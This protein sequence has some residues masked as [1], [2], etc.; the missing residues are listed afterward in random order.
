MLRSIRVP[1]F[2]GFVAL[3]FA[4][5]GG[6][7]G[8]GHQTDG[9][10][11]GDGPHIQFDGSHD[12]TTPQQDGGGGGDGG[13]GACVATGGV[14]TAGICKNSKPCTCPNDCVVQVQDSP[15]GSCW[16]KPD[17]TNGC[18]NATDVAIYYD[19]QDNAHC[20]PTA[21]LT[22]TF[23]VPIA[24]VDTMAGTS[25]VTATI[26]GVT[27]TPTQGFAQHSTSSWFIALE[28]ADAAT[29]PVN[30]VIIDIGDALYNTTTPINMSNNA[31]ADVSLLQYTANA[32]IMYGRAKEGTLTLTTADTGATGT[33]A[34]SFSAT[35][36][37]FGTVGEMCGPNTD[38]C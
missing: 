4:A 9:G 12:G 28:P 7:G 23:S 21:T 24:T 22:G 1:I 19:T 8:G 25:T 30:I 11:T 36:K 27:F 14:A 2:A 38:P 33:V 29:P 6:G 31:N 34:G 26:N 37:M 5:C 32:E 3:L 13:G 20:Y 15:A 18:E 17:P 16:P 10:S 35:F